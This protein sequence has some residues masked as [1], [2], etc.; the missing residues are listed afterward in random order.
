MA[1]ALRHCTEILHL[2]PK[3]NIREKR[4]RRKTNEDLLAAEWD[5]SLYRVV[6]SF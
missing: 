1:T 3:G 5:C 2:A 6:L 4:R